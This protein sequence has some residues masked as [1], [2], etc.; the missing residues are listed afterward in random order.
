[1]KPRNSIIES[2][3]IILTGAA[4]LTASAA[5]NVSEAIGVLEN[6][7]PASA[8]I[9]TIK[10][11]RKTIDVT[12]GRGGLEFNA[13]AELTNL[14]DDQIIYEGPSTKT[15][16]S[17]AFLTIYCKQKKDC[18]EVTSDGKWNA[19]ALLIETNTLDAEKVKNAIR[20]LIWLNQ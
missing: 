10:V 19:P 5:M 17:F 11:D 18:V 7:H 12:S 16:R 15:R 1:M 13:H 2:G 14:D 3:L 9:Q 8:A 6:V 20:T 4:G